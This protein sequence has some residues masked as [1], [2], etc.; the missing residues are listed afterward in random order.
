MLR[1]PS[2]V[3][4]V[5]LAGLSGCN[6][7]DGATAV[8]TLLMASISGEEDSLARSE[9]APADFLPLGR[10]CD[11]NGAFDELFV[12]YDTD[13]SGDL[14]GQESEDARGDW[15]VDRHQMM[16]LDIL[17]N[18]YDTD[19]S[20]DLSD[21]ER[22]VLLD[23]FTVRCE[24]LA[25][26]L[27]EEFDADGDGVLSDAELE[28]ARAALEERRPEEKAEMEARC[29]GATASAEGERPAGPPDGAPA[30]GE[31][32]PSP[33]IAEFDADGDGSLSAAEQANLVTVV[34]A[35]IRA[36]ELPVAPPEGAPP[37]E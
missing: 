27:T 16:M 13:A 10:E 30:E 35:R 5:L 26:K 18:V 33:L 20:G 22:A 21:A 8:E 11:A 36:G 31:L 32:P 15:P 19:G 12:M 25:A 23:D 14:A 7:D 37:T 3:A 1:H 4:V 17:H 24:T 28:V 29:E 6:A 9:S 2:L 34:R